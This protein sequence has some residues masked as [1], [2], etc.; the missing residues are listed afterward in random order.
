V[1]NPQVF[2]QILA[3]TLE[4]QLQN[5]LSSRQCFPPG[6]SPMYPKV[7][8]TPKCPKKSPIIGFG[9][10]TLLA[11]LNRN[12]S[13]TTLK[14]FSVEKAMSVRARAHGPLKSTG[15]QV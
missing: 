13:L 9:S 8:G 7:Y 14:L 1:H 11:L 2:G 10:T 3:V 4:L 15:K 5:S 6:K 12:N